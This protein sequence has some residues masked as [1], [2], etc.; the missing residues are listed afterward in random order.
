MKILAKPTISSQFIT[1]RLVSLMGPLILFIGLS[2]TSSSWAK[3]GNI[4]S[5]LDRLEKKL[6]E[7]KQEPF[8]LEDKWN[9][10]IKN[11]KRKSYRFKQTT[12][13]S[14][15]PSQA[16]LDEIGKA[17]DKIQLEVNQLSS[18]MERMKQSIG[19][20]TSIDTK[21]VIETEILKPQSTVVRDLVIYIDDFEVFK[22][23]P[24][25]RLWAPKKIIPIYSGFIHPG[26]HKVTVRG[27]VARIMSKTLPIDDN[28]FNIIEGKH[29]IEVGSEKFK[30]G[31]SIKIDEPDSKKHKIK[32]NIVEYS[33]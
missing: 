27:R 33:L 6:M 19:D 8:L 10:P 16:G 1:R 15:L 31:I 11:P 21:L 14:N 18:D 22:L 3:E 5:I 23:N 13:A 2:F 7:T 28:T 9:Q 12:I 26:T 4:D 24:D 20:K 29:T 30:K 17:I 32:A 25:S